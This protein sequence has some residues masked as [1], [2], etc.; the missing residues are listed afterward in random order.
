MFFFKKK[1]SSWFGL[2]YTNSRHCWTGVKRPLNFTVQKY[3]NHAPEKKEADE[4]HCCTDG[5]FRCKAAHELFFQIVGFPSC[6]VVG[7][8]VS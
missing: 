5:A 3:K 4:K 6:W 7:F 8:H 2:A 1:L